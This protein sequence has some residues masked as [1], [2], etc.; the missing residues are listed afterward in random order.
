MSCH[1]KHRNILYEQFLSHLSFNPLHFWVFCE[2]VKR[3]LHQNLYAYILPSYTHN[4]VHK[5]IYD[6]KKTL[7]VSSL[8]IDQSS[9]VSLF[10]FLSVGWPTFL[11]DYYMNFIHLFKQKWNQFYNWIIDNNREE[12]LE[13]IL[14]YKFKNKKKVYNTYKWE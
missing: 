10:L 2:F 11:L 13:A 3:P 12:V 6:K 5:K 4:I 9:C 7:N 8:E 14:H 1:Q